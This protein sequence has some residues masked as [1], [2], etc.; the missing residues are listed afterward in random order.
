MNDKIERLKEIIK[1][2]TKLN[3][4][5]PNNNGYPFMQLSEVE[6]CMM[7]M[8]NDF[9]LNLMREWYKNKEKKE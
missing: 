8:V 4:M 2:A 9:E 5:S 3:W 1:I 6:K 7:A